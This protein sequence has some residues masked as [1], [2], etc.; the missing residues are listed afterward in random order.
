MKN[1]LSR[2]RFIQRTAVAA[3]GLTL[4]PNALCA[5]TKVKRTA[6]DQVTLGKTG[7]KLSRLGMGTGSNNGQGQRG[8]G[9]GAFNDLVHYAYD[10]GITYF[11]CAKS[12]VSFD[13][14]GAAIKPL[15][16]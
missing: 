4:A 12:Y 16:R 11:D 1:S 2:R 7:I 9:Q 6:V 8:L 14:V 15:P 10:Q 3:T 5:E 13:W